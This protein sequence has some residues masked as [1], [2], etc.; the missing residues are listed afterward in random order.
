MIFNPTRGGKKPVRKE[1]SVRFTS[2][3]GGAIY[4]TL[5]G[6]ASKQIISGFE[7]S[8]AFDAGTYITFSTIPKRVTGATSVLGVQVG[9]NTTIY[10]VDP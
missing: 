1:I 10:I 6:V 8:T 2:S 5:D 7:G 4:G 3:A 9:S